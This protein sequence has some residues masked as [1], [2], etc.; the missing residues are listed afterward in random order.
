MSN[1]YK[2]NISKETFKKALNE[3]VK[4]AWI[5]NSKENFLQAVEWKNE[6][7]FQYN[8]KEAVDSEDDFGGDASSI[9]I[10]QTY[11]DSV[12]EGERSQEFLKDWEASWENENGFEMTKFAGESIEDGNAVGEAAREYFEALN[13]QENI[14]NNSHYKTFSFEHISNFDV[15][16]EHT[17]KLLQNAN[18]YSYLFEAAFEFD[19]KNL[20]T[21]CDILKIKKDKHVEIIE[22]KGTSKV[23]SEHFFDLMYQVIVLEKNGYIVDDIAICHL[24]KNYLRGR[25]NNA[26]FKSIGDE[27][28][29]YFETFDTITYEEVVEA[30]K[31][32]PGIE[33]DKTPS[34]LNYDEY[35]LV[36]KLSFGTAATRPTLKQELN[37]FRSVFNVEELIKELTDILVDKT[38]QILEI[39]ASETCGTKVK[40][41]RSGQWEKT[42]PYCYHAVE[43]FNKDQENVF[44]F[45]GGT[46]LTNEKKAKFFHRE[47]LCYLDDISLEKF[48]KHCSHCNEYEMEQLE[49]DLAD[50]KK[51]HK[52]E[53]KNLP[54]EERWK[55]SEDDQI[56]EIK[57]SIEELKATFYFSYKH[58]R[59]FE[60]Y[61]N[62]DLIAEDVTKSING[63]TYFNLVSM[64]RKYEDYPVYMYDFETVK[65]AIPNFDKSSG[66]QQIPFQYSVDII[67]DDKYD[68]WNPET[69]K[70]YDFIGPNRFDPRPYFIEQFIVDMFSEGPG[71]YV[72][73]NDSFEKSVLKY[74][75]YIYPEYAI[76]LLYIVQNTIDLMDF[77]K[78]NSKR[79]IP[80]FLVYHPGFHG[81][82]SIKKTQPSLEPGFNYSDLKINKGDKASQ[83]FREYVDGNIPLK[84]WEETIKPDMIKYCNRDTLAMVVI[85]KKIEEIAAKYKENNYG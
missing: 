29:E 42:A 3:C 7:K 20:R 16:V 24:Q 15:A 38:G 21:R 43:Y 55:Q 36:D 8:L 1:I 65:W 6:Y 53:M 68:Y 30:I 25:D 70:H 41:T 26:D 74:L 51:I 11:I 32:A 40:R 37:S 79:D 73:Y 45:T 4:K 52:D 49:A 47:K 48:Q 12:N 67:V 56:N 78:G 31:N 80:W 33:K 60:T 77:F 64:L 58:H 5:F 27:A 81:S 57:A 22:V 84:A 83:T 2:T 50:A 34:D 44:N 62:K 69:M 9:D 13:E 18:E 66:Y 17:K 82:Y 61:L 46:D 19:N 59:H 76:P 35:F 72:A 75:A 71:V 54:K 39:F 28:K 14:T 23:K 85:L 10:F 63:D